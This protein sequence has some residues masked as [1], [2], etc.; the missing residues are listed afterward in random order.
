M[1]LAIEGLVRP[2]GVPDGHVVTV[3]L[4]S[5]PV[6]IALARAVAHVLDGRQVGVGA[7]RAR[8]RPPVREMVAGTA[9]PRE[10][11]EDLPRVRGVPLI[12]PQGRNP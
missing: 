2:V 3:P 11:Q 1:A 9:A 7:G 5:H 10:G 6:D 8:H 12:P 4:G